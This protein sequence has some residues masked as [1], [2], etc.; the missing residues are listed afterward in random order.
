M[1]V[2]ALPIWAKFNELTRHSKLYQEF[3]ARTQL[4]TRQSLDN[5]TQHKVVV[6]APWHI[7]LWLVDADCVVY[8][9]APGTTLDESTSVR[10]PPNDTGESIAALLQFSLKAAALLTDLAEARPLIL[11]KLVVKVHDGEQLICGLVDCAATLDFV[12]EDS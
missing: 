12:S 11:T 1:D 9:Q 10:V 5:P 4:F 3:P 8:D 2:F 6:L 7:Q